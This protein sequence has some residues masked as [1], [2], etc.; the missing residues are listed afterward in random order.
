[1]NIFVYGT[2]KRGHG[3]Y[4]RLMRRATFL[5]DAI[6]APYWRLGSCGSFPIL[7]RGNC[8]V[9]GE[10]FNVDRATLRQLDRLES[11][12]TMYQ[13]RRIYVT[14]EDG[15]LL[16][17]WTYVGNPE[18]WSEPLPQVSNNNWMLANV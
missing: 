3:N 6:T 11:E 7:Q 10:V 12:G 13:R 8:C 1:M 17:C 9:H 14:M 4:E 2:L 16:R 18:F 5:G 15:G